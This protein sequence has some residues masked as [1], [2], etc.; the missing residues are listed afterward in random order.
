M[1]Q[2]VFAAAVIYV[3]LGIAFAVYFVISGVS[4]LDAVANESPV[5]FKVLIIPAS[6]ALWPLLAYKLIRHRGVQ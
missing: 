1:G 3:V 5:S 4:R 2:I 6:V